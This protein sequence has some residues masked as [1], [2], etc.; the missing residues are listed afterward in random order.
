LGQDNSAPYTWTW[1][2]APAGNYTLTAD[3]VYNG[4]S[5]AA[6]PPVGIFVLPSTIQPH[7]AISG[8]NGI[9]Q[10]SWPADHTGWRLLAQT[11]SN[12]VGLS[13]NWSMVAGSTNADQ[14]TIPVPV[15]GQSIFYRLVYP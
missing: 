11:N 7:L 9:Y 4:S 14:I 10:L 8:T 13:T 3:A 5:T 1:T 6:S 2:N 12:T 15:G